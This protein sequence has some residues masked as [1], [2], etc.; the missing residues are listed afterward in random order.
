MRREG[1]FAAM[2]SLATVVRLDLERMPRPDTLLIAEAWYQVALSRNLRWASNDSTGLNAGLRCLA[3]LEARADAPDTLVYVAHN[4]VGWTY[5][6]LRQS[7]GGIQ[8][9][10]AAVAIAR[11]HPEWGP[12]QLSSVLYNMGT[13]LMNIGASD[14]A[15]AAFEESLGLRRRLALPRDI[16]PGEIYAGMGMVY[17]Q[18]GRADLAEEAF[19]SAIRSDEEQVGPDNWYLIGPLSRA[20]AFEFHRGDYA[21]SI[22]YNA[23]ALG[24]VGGK[25]PPEDPN[26]FIISYSIAQSLEALGDVERALAVYERVLPEME[27][28][29]GRGHTEVLGGWI[30]LASANAEVGR[31]ERALEIYEHVRA[32]FDE[33]TSQTQRATLAAALVGEARLRDGRGEAD[34][35]LSLALAAERINRADAAAEPTATLQALSLQMEIHARRGEWAGVDRVD[36]EMSREIDRLAF[37]GNNQSD[38]VWTTRSEVAALRGRP[39]DAVSAA[40][41]GAR[42]AGQRLTRNVRALSDRQS[43]L[44]ASTLSEPLDQ[45]LYVG[46]RSGSDPASVRRSW[47]EVVRWRGLVR[48]EVARRRLPPRVEADSTLA[49]AHAAWVRAQRRLAQFE[50]R[51]ASVGREPASDS[52]VAALRADVDEAERRLALLSPGVAIERDPEKVG[53]DS[54]LARLAPDQALVGLVQAPDSLGGRHLCALVSTG[55]ATPVRSID[56]G[57]VEDLEGLVATWKAELGE[58]DPNRRSEEACRRAGARVRERVWDPIARA[59]GGVGDVYLVPE[60]PVTGLSWGALPDGKRGYLVEAGPR[61]HVLGAER[62]LLPAPAAVQGQGLLAVGGVTFDRDAPPAGPRPLTIA[63]LFRAPLAECDSTALSHLP[64]LPAT[65]EEVGDVATAWARGPA[66]LGP[67]TRLEGS[68]ATEAEFKRLAANRRVI[69]LATHGIVLSDTCGR[70]APG[71]RGV[72][73]VGPLSEPSAV[74]AAPDAVPGGKALAAPDRRTPRRP[75]PWLGRRVLLALADANHASEHAGDENE[76]LLAAEEVTTLDLRGVDW[77]VLSACQSAA[78]EEWTREGVLGMQR[79]FHLAGA[80]TVIASQWSVDDEATREWVRALYEARSDGASRAADAMSAASTTIL[81]ARRESGR[82]THPFYWAAFT[83]SGE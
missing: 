39:A 17:E 74:A 66:P 64:P 25:V 10:E 61:I 60:A 1:R 28:R 83:A 13:A 72:G 73:A 46:V 30:S 57:R 11:R 63:A 75:S 65:A 78:G 40:S 4:Q 31:D 29:I 59:T 53:I 41:E 5:T 16:L 51:A 81:R 58:P 44:L 50:V 23:R 52:T 79:A 12:T 26:P 48:A 69:H 15:L 70:S 6:Q 56:L 49:A 3:L 33:D 80:R 14:S 54:V 35:A 18:Q 8:H 47:D 27:S 71:T 9:Y 67:S 62:D 77:V 24:I 21:R 45:L 43:L 22:D 2:E 68:A 32:V 38:V 36:A 42:G 34:S 82:S 20:A 55:A 76:G 7:P 19:A 37:R